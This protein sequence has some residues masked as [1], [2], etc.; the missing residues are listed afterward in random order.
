MEE[1]T[2][3][4]YPSSGTVTAAAS[5]NT[6]P[7]AANNTVTA[8]AGTAYAFA[9]DDFGFMD[10]DAGAALASVK[11]ESLP[12][13]G[14]LALAGTA[15]TL[16]EVVTK[17]QIDDGNLTFTPV[18][19]A[20]GTGYATF[21]FKVNDGTVDSDS[22][23]T[24]T[25]DVRDLSCA[26]PDFAGDNRR[27]LWTGIVTAGDVRSVGYGFHSEESQTGLDDTTFAI[28]RNSYTVDSAF[29]LSVSF[30]GRLSFGLTGGVND[31][32]TAGEVAALR[33][34]VCDTA[35]YNFSAATLSLD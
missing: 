25:I 14:T 22:A 16:N 15:V 7:T 28:G 6:A 31:N 19:G 9:A 10:A 12:A 23:Y 17:A 11:I 20:S 3:A 21:T 34:H 24:M 4:A 2:S 13:V 32:L 29:V 30:V 1:R 5:T 33:L 27:E 26:A 8:V 18:D 35:I